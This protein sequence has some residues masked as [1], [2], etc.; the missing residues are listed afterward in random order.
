MSNRKSL[1]GLKT[2]SKSNGHNDNDDAYYMKQ[3]LDTKVI[4]LCFSPRTLE[5]LKDADVITLRDL[6][7]IDHSKVQWG[8]ASYTEVS[9]LIESLNLSFDNSPL[10]NKFI[11]QV[12][13]FNESCA[14]ALPWVEQTI[15]WE[16]AEKDFIA[17]PK[18]YDDITL[19]DDDE[20]PYVIV[21][22]KKF[23]MP[24]DTFDN[25]LDSFEESLLK[26]E[27]FESEEILTLIGIK[28]F[29]R[30]RQVSL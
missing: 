12:S 20:N 11:S 9:D 17:H 23:Y 4:D 8:K 5:V 24:K 28:K 19:L 29:V 26:I 30:K 2:N 10:E 3:L 21:K 6:V 13:E 22:G 16:E 1:N 7:N 27:D 14:A 18:K 15:K 25:F